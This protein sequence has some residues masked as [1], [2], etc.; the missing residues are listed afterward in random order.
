MVL[1]G[2]TIYSGARAPAL[3][4]MRVEELSSL[5]LKCGVSVKTAAAW[6]RH[7]GFDT[8]P[9]L[10]PA[11]TG[12]VYGQRSQEAHRRHAQLKCLILRGAG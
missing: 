7:A 3:R 4:Q 6:A 8:S 10:H 1:V 9:E 12:L 2:P 5:F 11:V